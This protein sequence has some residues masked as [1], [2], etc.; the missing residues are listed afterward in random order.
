MPCKRCVTKPIV[1]GDWETGFYAMIAW[2][3]GPTSS[4]VDAVRMLEIYISGLPRVRKVE[5]RGL[6]ASADTTLTWQSLISP[7]L[8]WLDCLSANS[9]TTVPG[10]IISNKI[11]KQKTG[12]NHSLNTLKAF[13]SRRLMHGLQLFFLFGDKSQGSE[14]QHYYSFIPT[15]SKT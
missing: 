1:A 9:D 7:E 13:W 15:R 14:I 3:N 12:K 6:A 8:N 2:Y 4:N 5:I 11:F 10:H